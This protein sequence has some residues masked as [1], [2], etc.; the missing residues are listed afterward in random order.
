MLFGW[1]RKRRR[2]RLL[3]E[4]FPEDWLKHLH[5]NVPY[6]HQLEEEDKA[7]LRDD[8]RVF[9]A[10]QTWEGCK[11]LEVTDEMR[12]T[13]SALACLLTLHLEEGCY[14]RVQSILIYP[15]PYK[16]PVRTVVVP[17]IAAEDVVVTGDVS[18]LGR[19]DYDGPVTLA[20]EE[21]ADNLHHPG[22]G[23]NLVF[24]EFAHRID[25]L[26]GEANGVPPL[27]DPEQY[28]RWQQVMS[29]EYRRFVRDLERGRD[30]LL[31]EDGAEDEAE[32]FAVA[33]E[34][35]FDQ[36]AELRQ[37]HPQLYDLLRDYYRQDPAA[38]AQHQP[39]A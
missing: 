21:L 3:A 25:M 27:R 10:E 17:N 4:P 37:R 31:D 18:L 22:G 26:D 30:T 2:Q 15:G 16:A 12:V 11:G 8:L 13:V 24:H 19:A 7:K 1:L 36:S 28:V 39:E 32:F 35:F 9:A 34:S 20:W 14:D 23:R 38:R 6:Y 33:T 29:A 5:G